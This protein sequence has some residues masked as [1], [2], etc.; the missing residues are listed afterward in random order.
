VPGTYALSNSC[1]DCPAGSDCLNGIKTE[2]EIGSYSP[3]KSPNCIVCGPG[4]NTSVNGS[5][6][7]L[8]C[9]S[10]SYCVNGISSPCKVGFSDSGSTSCTPCIAGTYLE[11][12]QC[13]DFPTC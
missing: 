1:S 13:L 9:E 6:S 8:I 12:N 10:G 2:C 4:N 5:T 11:D 7:C 3:S